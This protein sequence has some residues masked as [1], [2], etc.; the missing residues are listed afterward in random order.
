MQFVSKPWRP[1]FRFQH[2]YAPFAYVFVGVHTIVW[3]DF[4]YLFKSR[5]A[6]LTNISHPVHEYAV[7]ALCKAFYFGVVLAI[8][9]LVLPVPWWQVLLGYLAM[10][11]A[12][13]LVFVFLLIGTHFSDATAFPAVDA[14]GNLGRT[15]A[16]HNLDTACDWAPHSW[17]A[18]FFVGGVNAHAS[19]HLF[20]GVSHAHYRAIAGIIEATAAEYGLRYNKLTLPGIVRSHFR[21][22][23]ALGRRPAQSNAVFE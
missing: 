3:Q 15:W 17:F 2:L 13:S 20:P 4:V 9:I 11:A 23:R 8:P 19:H 10:S 16:Q 5:L 14:D 6:N 22:L 7:F 18:H 12:A 1:R 21:F